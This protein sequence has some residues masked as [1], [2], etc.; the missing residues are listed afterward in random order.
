MYCA[1]TVTPYNINIVLYLFGTLSSP[2]ALLTV[3]RNGIYFKWLS[4]ILEA[5]KSDLLP[6]NEWFLDTV[7]RFRMRL[8]VGTWGDVAPILHVDVDEVLFLLALD[9]SWN[10]L[11][12]N[13]FE[14]IPLETG[15][16]SLFLRFFCRFS[17]A[18]SPFVD[19]F[20]NKTAV[21]KMDNDIKTKV[22]KVMIF[23]KTAIKRNSADK[24]TLKSIIIFRRISFSRGIVE[25]KRWLPV[26]ISSS[27]RSR[28]KCGGGVSWGI[29]EPNTNIDLVWILTQ[30]YFQNL[31]YLPPSKI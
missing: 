19:H 18:R 25:I 2:K 21:H 5:L 12:K 13:M 23:T 31:R 26:K 22:L 24:N 27:G 6:E 8:S 20:S 17:T 30:I 29:D 10:D 15:N 11:L 1:P 14:N 9:L 4:V 3:G 16:C 7:L 28:Y